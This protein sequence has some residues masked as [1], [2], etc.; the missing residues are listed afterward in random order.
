[1]NKRPNT[2]VSL[3]LVS[4]ATTIDEALRRLGVAKRSAVVVSSGGK[5]HVIASAH[6]IQAAS[7]GR[8]KVGDVEPI[9]VVD[10]KETVVA[11]AAGSQRSLAP[12]RAA[13]ASKE[14]LK[15]VIVPMPA[16]IGAAL[17][18]SMSRCV[19]LNPITPHGPYLPKD[20]GTKCKKC[21]Y[22]VVC[23]LA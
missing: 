9:T 8:T 17:R 6:M 22:R 13:G 20:A 1:M 21:D 16:R 10:K 23:R 15:K 19:C 12:A 18:S 11:R 14:P 2:R 5:L 4:A 3:P 7:S